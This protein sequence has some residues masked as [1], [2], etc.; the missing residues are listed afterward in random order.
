MLAYVRLKEGAVEGDRP[1]HFAD[2][3]E[4]EG[5]PIDPYEYDLEALCGYRLPGGLILVQ[6]RLNSPLCDLCVLE[7]LARL[8]S[9]NDER[10]HPPRF[11]PAFEPCRGRA[12]VSLLL[13]R[14][15]RSSTP[16]HDPAPVPGVLVQSGRPVRRQ[17]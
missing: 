6:A 12:Q 17:Q 5:Y 16:E 1:V 9:R 4:Y 7:Q 8:R 11:E 15:G 3:P 13:A 14:E 10:V 2:V